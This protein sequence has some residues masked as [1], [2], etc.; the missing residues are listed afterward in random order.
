[1]IDYKQPDYLPILQKR[2]DL[3]QRLQREPHTLAAFKLHYKTNPVDFIND[4]G[5]TYDPR[6]VARKMPAF[7]PFLLFPKQEDFILWLY[8]SFLIK[9][10]GLA[11]KSRDMGFTWLAVSFSVWLWLFHDG[12]KVGWGSRKEQLVDRLGDPDS[13]FEKMRMFIRLLPSVFLPIGYDEK[14][15]ATYLKI[16]NPAN[17]SVI[18][19]EAGD[20]IG[21]GGRSSI[22]F[23][24]ESA[25]YERPE[26]VE[27]A[28]SQN[29]DVKIDISTP[30]GN[31][32]P[33]YVKRF[34]GKIRVFT[35]NWRDDPRK[36]DD[37]YK[38]QCD[39][40]DP[41]TVAQEIDI[42]YDASVENICIPASWVAAAVN[43]PLP[44]EGMKFAGYDVAD[45]GGDYYAL[46]KRHGNFVYHVEKWKDGTT[47]QSTRK[48]FNACLEDKVDVINYDSVG[49][50][51]GAKGE[52]AE[53]NTNLQFSISGINT[54]DS[55]PH[56]TYRDT[57]RLNK[58]MFLNLKAYLW[59][60][61]RLR[62][63]RTY[64]AKN[65]LATFPPEELISIPNN[66]ELISELS[67]P[68][69]FLAENGKIQIESKKDMKKRGTPSPNLADALMLSFSP[70]NGDSLAI[71]DYMKQIAAANKG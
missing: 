55:V 19:G 7:M 18:A 3:L 67:R 36:D 59:W 9:E 33:F 68:K 28:L 6:M 10:D 54:G 1:M 47:T 49:V 32:N 66:T 23:K 5:M 35:M 17:G 56:G 27:A 65:E 20:N 30:N 61:M 46:I 42:D 39:T 62:F 16:I 41:V 8:E 13:I 38:K 60:D 45:E 63:K 14:K 24:D 37:W 44:K 15:H 34:S 26:K 31:G 53:L 64:E 2:I 4:W 22:Y 57:G 25:F 12:V 43:Y 58:D 21:R 29:S 11:E 69:Y 52:F 51:A 48:V 70:Q 71:L 40:L 50:G